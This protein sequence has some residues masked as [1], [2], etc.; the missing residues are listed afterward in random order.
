[1]I[2]KKILAM[3]AQLRADGGQPTEENIV[4]LAVAAFDELM[5]EELARSLQQIEGKPESVK[6]AYTADFQQAYEDARSK[7]L[8][9]IIAAARSLAAN[10]PSS[11]EVGARIAT[12]P[13]IH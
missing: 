13:T 3:V 11:I 7:W 12:G 1:M 2:E 4:K 10:S 5:A 9:G 8:P 6:S